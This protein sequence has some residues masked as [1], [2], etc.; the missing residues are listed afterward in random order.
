MPSSMIEQQTCQ[1]SHFCS[2]TGGH[3]ETRNLDKFEQIFDFSF[4]D[5]FEFHK[6]DAEFGQIF[7][8]KLWALVSM[9][10]QSLTCS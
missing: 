3:D 5:R 10:V 4:L 7:L 9:T 2:R 6:L 8:G 1:T